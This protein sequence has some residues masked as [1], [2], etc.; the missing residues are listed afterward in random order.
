MKQT[1]QFPTLC[2]HA[3]QVPDPH[4]GAVMPPISLSST[5]VQR[6]PGVHSG[7]EYSRA[8]NPT[9]FAWERCIAALES[10]TRAWAYASGMAACNAVLDLLDAGSHVVASEDLYGGSYRLFERVRGS[11]S[12]LSVTYV[13]MR[14]AQNIA[15][16]IRPETKLIWVETPSNPL[17]HLADLP[18]LAALAKARGL[19][20]V[21]DNTFASPFLQRPLESGFDVVVHSATK[22]LN[23]HSDVV[24]GVAVVGENRDVAER[25]RFLHNATGAIAGPFDAYLALRGVKTLALRMERHCANALELAGWLQAH[26]KIARAHYPGLSSHPQHALAQRQMPRGFGGMI[27]VELRADAEGTRRFL[28]STQL[29]ALA[30]SLGGVESLIGYPAVMSHAALPAAERARLGITDSVCRLS[31]GVEHVDDLRADLD[32]ALARV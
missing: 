20:T 14:D 32:A 19:L 16:A 28:E 7:F 13:D 12:N 10:G 11:T 21:A 6:S 9:R 26:P 17:L 27:A 18:T 31:V 22:Y 23:G 24:G 4:T 3:G 2:I 15:R 8:Q 1:P 25:L 29:F 5:Y 30:E